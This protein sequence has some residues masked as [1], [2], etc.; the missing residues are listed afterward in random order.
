MIE[1]YWA[2]TARGRGL[3]EDAPRHRRRRLRRQPDLAPVQPRAGRAAARRP[4]GEERRGRT[5]PG[6]RELFGRG[7]GHQPHP[8]VRRCLKLVA[9]TVQGAHQDHRPGPRGHGDGRSAHGSAHLV[10]RHH[11][12]PPHDRPRRHGP[13]RHQGDQ[14]RHRHH[15]QRRRARG[16]RRRA[17]RLPRGPR[18][19]ARQ[20]A[21]RHRAGLGARRSRSSSGGATRSRRCSP[22]SAPTSRTR[23]SGSRTWPTANQNAKEHHKAISAD[24]LQ[25]WAEFAAPRTFGLAVRMSPSLRLAEKHPV[26]HNLVISNVPGPAGAAVLHGRQ[27]RGALPARPGLPRRRPEHH[28]DVQRRPGRTSARSPAASRC[29]TSTTWLAA[30]PRRARARY[31]PGGPRPSRKVTPIRRP[32][33]A[34]K[35]AAE[36]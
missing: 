6:R 25:D 30:V 8:A 31:A 27:D 11:H 10:Q 5:T 21:A 13:R 20:L 9:P 12:R 36:A 24:T 15:R 4:A 22:G 35:K 1:G 17:A 18:R 23:S 19:A 32:R 33:E 28:R 2:S 16:G 34:P 7:R 29:R 26:I 14:E 3:H